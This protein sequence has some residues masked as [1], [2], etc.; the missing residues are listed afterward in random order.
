MLKSS[1]SSPPPPR[2][3]ARRPIFPFACDVSLGASAD[4]SSTET[5][6][7]DGAGFQSEE[8][9]WRAEDSLSRDITRPLF[10]DLRPIGCGG[11]SSSSSGIAVSRLVE[12]VLRSEAEESLHD[13]AEEGL[14]VAAA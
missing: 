14:F 2:R 9:E 4:R 12:D 5:L 7:R 6:R 11:N 3:R 10:G 13:I 1:P 8:L